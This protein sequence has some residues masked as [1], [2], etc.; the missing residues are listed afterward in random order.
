MG[1]DYN[2]ISLE[3]IAFNTPLFYQ[4]KGKSV[5]NTE[6]GMMVCAPKWKIVVHDKLSFFLTSYMSN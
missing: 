4:N 5:L 2:V 6:K 1:N 3:F